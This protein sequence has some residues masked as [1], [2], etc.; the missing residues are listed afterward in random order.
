MLVENIKMTTKI[1]WS[2]YTII[3]LLIKLLETMI[4]LILIRDTITA[5]ILIKRTILIY[6]K[7]NLITVPNI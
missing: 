3:R 1:L 2:N 5:T 7:K 6:C 4:E